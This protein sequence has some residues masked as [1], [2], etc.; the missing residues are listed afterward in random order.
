V[1]FFDDAFQ[2]SDRRVHAMNKICE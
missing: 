1:I 2:R